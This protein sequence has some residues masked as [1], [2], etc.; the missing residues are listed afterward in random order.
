MWRGH[1]Y[2]K[3]WL[4]TRK[5][6]VGWS[7]GNTKIKTFIEPRG[8]IFPVIYCTLLIAMNRTRQIC[9]LSAVKLFSA[10]ALGPEDLL[11][12]GSRGFILG[13]PGTLPRAKIEQSLLSWRKCHVD[14]G[15]QWR[16]KLWLKIQIFILKRNQCV[17]KEYFCP[18]SVFLSKWKLN[19][20]T[21]CNATPVVK[22][23]SSS[24]QKWSY[25]P[26][27][28]MIVITAKPFS[29]KKIF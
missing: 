1:I 26:F 18:C 15:F 27:L 23:T 11:T 12:G 25:S 9:I 5:F 13:E 10:N 14:T 19:P 24:A 3:E 6:N 22:M 7:S 16:Q 8:V 20:L 21:T 4:F 28:K 2:F 29:K 17:T